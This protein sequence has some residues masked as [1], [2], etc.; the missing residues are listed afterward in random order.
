MTTHT[1]QTRQRT[2]AA[3][4]PAPL[5]LTLPGV[6]APQHDTALLLRSL[7]REHI[8]EGIDVLDLGTGSGALAIAAA[9]RGARVTAVDVSLRAVATAWLNARLNRQTVT[10]RRADLATAS[11]PGAYDLVVSNPPYVPSPALPR[12]GTSRAWDAGPAGRAI[13]DRVCDAA[14]RTLRP[15]GVLLLVHSGLCGTAETLGRL[16]HLKMS[17]EVTARE[18]IPFEPV[19][20]R[21]EQWLRRQGLLHD[22]E[23]SEELVVFRAAL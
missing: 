13:V 4:A 8:D 14:A 11:P 18:H 22:Y 21:R 19:L 20:R 7:A 23:N 3:P 1:P 6:Y 5:V 17:A 9:R 16:E 12:R 10:V 15:G 2:V